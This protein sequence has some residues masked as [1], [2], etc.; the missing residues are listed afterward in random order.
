ET[1]RF[2]QRR[3]LLGTPRKPA[4][5]IRRYGEEDLARVRFIKTAQALGFRLDEVALF[6][7]LDDGLH[8]ADARVIA[9]QKLKHVGRARARVPHASATHFLSVDCVVAEGLAIC[10]P[11]ELLHILDMA[12]GRYYADF[13]FRRGACARC[14]CPTSAFRRREPAAPFER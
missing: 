10:A 1:I 6:L 7:K 2:Y 9:E 12:A 4:G 3:G 11:A 5:G 13:A 14:T 8:C